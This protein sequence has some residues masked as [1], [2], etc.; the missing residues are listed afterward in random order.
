ML[1][2]DIDLKRGKLNACLFRKLPI[3]LLYNL[4]I[5]HMVNGHE[6][7]TCVY[8]SFQQDMYRAE[9]GELKPIAKAREEI[10]YEIT[11]VRWTLKWL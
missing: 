2:N 8:H 1:I 11:I 3:Y 6:M 9:S 10:K 4:R 5:I 7:Y